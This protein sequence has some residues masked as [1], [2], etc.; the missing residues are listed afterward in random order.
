MIYINHKN[1]NELYVYL[2]SLKNFLYLIKNRINSRYSE[3]EIKPYMIMLTNI[4]TYHLPYLQFLYDK[5]IERDI[6][7]ELLDL[8]YYLRYFAKT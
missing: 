2:K 4:I 5:K 6:V 8:I 3:N 7:V 1:P